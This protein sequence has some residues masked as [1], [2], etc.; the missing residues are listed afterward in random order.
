MIA[1]SWKKEGM[2]N[3]CLMSTGFQF[4]KERRVLQIDNVDDYK[5]M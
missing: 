5:T 2:S 1:R 4:A 3:Q